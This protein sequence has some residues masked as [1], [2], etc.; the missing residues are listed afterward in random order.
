M[1]NT[2]TNTS[3]PFFPP[4]HDAAERI[5]LATL[6]EGDVASVIDRRGGQDENPLQEVDSLC[7]TCGEQVS[8]SFTPRVHASLYVDQGRTRMLLTS[9]PYFKEI[10][11]MSFRCEHC[12]ATNN[13]VQSASAARGEIK[14]L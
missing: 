6:G 8:P 5:D 13:D 3:D 14:F 12:G 11:I 10:I 2:S 1:P 9:I 7:M 4:I